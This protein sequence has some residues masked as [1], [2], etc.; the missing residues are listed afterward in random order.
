M[1]TL[2]CPKMIK[3]VVLEMGYYILALTLVWF[4]FG[5]VTGDSYWLIV[6]VIFSLLILTMMAVQYPSWRRVFLPVTLDGQGV[7]NRHC[8]LKWDEIARLE[9]FE[10][11]YSMPMRGIKDGFSIEGMGL[12]ICLYRDSKAMAREF[13]T[14]APYFDSFM[15]RGDRKRERYPLNDRIFLPYND[16]TLAL[17]RAHAPHL[18]QKAERG[19]L[20]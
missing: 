2:T 3:W 13:Y 14:Y 15:H 7:R 12:M 19:D 17:I 6:C 10:A 1:K 11:T 9:L 4:L 5:F 8:D 20:L 16:K 18:L